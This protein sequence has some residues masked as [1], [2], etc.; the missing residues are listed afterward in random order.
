MYVYRKAMRKENST[1]F[2]NEVDLTNNCG[3][4]YTISV[5]SGRWKVGILAALLDVDTLRYSEIKSTLGNITERML[6]KQLKELDHD[7]LI[8]RKDFNEMPPRVEYSLSGKGRE[9]KNILIEMYSW[10]KR[11]KQQ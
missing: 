4:F 9:L 6:I 3:M 1:N 7:G 11:N 2:I 5:I 8:I 10:G